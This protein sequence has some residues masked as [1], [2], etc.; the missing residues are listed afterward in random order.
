[1]HF[2]LR[3]DKLKQISHEEF[4]HLNWLPVTYRFKQCVIS[5]VFKYF[6]EQCP[7]CLN[8]VF[9]VATERNFKLRNSFQKLKYPFRQTNNDQYA[10]SY[11]GPTFW[12]KTPDTLKRSN[13]LNTFKHNFKKYIIKELKNSN[14][15]F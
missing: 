5:I 7:N 14:N 12:N 6:N 9:D 10:L 13:N 2:C 4:E 3:F 1:M 15:S 11:I 8:E